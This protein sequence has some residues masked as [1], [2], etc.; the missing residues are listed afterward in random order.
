MATLY[1]TEYASTGL[2]NENTMCQEPQVLSQTVAIGAGSA[3]SSAL[4]NNT[5]RVR[6]HAD[7]VC[8]VLFGTNPTAAATDRRMAAGQ[9]EYFKVTPGSG[10]KIATITNT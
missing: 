5:S 4:K 2:N 7:A 1:I 10:L 9:T 3:Q 6:L 8:S